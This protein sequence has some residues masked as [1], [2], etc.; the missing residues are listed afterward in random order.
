MGVFMNKKSFDKNNN[1]FGT[2][3]N[4]DLCQIMSSGHYQP[5]EIIE[6]VTMFDV[7]QLI[8]E[9]V[10]EDAIYKK[11]RILYELDYFDLIVRPLESV[12][13]WSG[14][15]TVSS[16]YFESRVKN[17]SFFDYQ[18]LSEFNLRYKLLKVFINNENQLCFCFPLILEGV[19]T[20]HLL[21]AIHSYMTDLQSA[22]KMI[23]ELVCTKDMDT[24]SKH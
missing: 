20:E 13:S 14:E 17:L 16:L 22:R 15:E 5:G 19:T 2:D 18:L 23:K 11:N 3:L 7:T 24:T 6:N 21:G 8:E 1:P 9:V 4:E 12:T 10:V